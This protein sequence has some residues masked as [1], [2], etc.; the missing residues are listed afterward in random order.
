MPLKSILIVIAVGVCALAFIQATTA[1]RNHS[2]RQAAES[3]ADTE[4]VTNYLR[5]NGYL[6]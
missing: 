6:D 1:V 3:A 4:R 5:Q 2:D